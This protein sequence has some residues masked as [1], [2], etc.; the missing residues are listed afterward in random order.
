M[1][2]CPPISRPQL[3]LE[4]FVPAERGKSKIADGRE[5][6]AVVVIPHRSAGGCFACCRAAE[7]RE[8][9]ALGR[10]PSGP[11]RLTAGF[12]L[13][14]LPAETPSIPTPPTTDYPP[15][16]DTPAS[17]SR[18]QIYSPLCSTLSRRP[19][20]PPGSASL[21]AVSSPPCL[22]SPRGDSPQQTLLRPPPASLSITALMRPYTLSGYL[23]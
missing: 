17:P 19:A 5:P 20:I 15:L 14:S 18:R 12:A 11:P 10:G 1:L 13:L 3:K 23:L 8:T 2:R 6:V 22:R 21:L 4:M 9:L 16:S 7:S